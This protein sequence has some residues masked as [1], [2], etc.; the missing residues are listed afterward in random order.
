M[1]NVFFVMVVGAGNNIA[2]K[3]DGGFT[4][5]V[6]YRFKKTVILFF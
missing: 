6:P 1:K 3:N 5:S 2:P 4:T